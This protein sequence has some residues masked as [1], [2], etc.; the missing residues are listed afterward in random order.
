MPVIKSAIK[1]LRQSKIKTERNRGVKREIK[2]LTD[3]FRK[4]PSAKLFSQLGS[5]L[6][7]AAKNN[8]I[9]PNKAA[10]LKSRLS[11]ALK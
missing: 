8:V 10:R 3:E 2:E 7:K 5:S 11:K 6:D 4:K 1:K 9:H